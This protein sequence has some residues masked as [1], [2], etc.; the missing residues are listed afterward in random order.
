MGNRTEQ[1]GYPEFINPEF[2]PFL[3]I[4]RVPGE[5]RYQYT[6]N[7]EGLHLIAGE[8]YRERERIFYI[9]QKST[10]IDFVPSLEDVTPSTPPSPLDTQLLVARGI[11]G[12][13]AQILDLI[14]PTTDILACSHGIGWEFLPEKFLTHLLEE[15]GFKVDEGYPRIG[16][17][18]RIQEH[19]ILLRK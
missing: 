18:K 11:I 8:Q 7:F 12:N 10:Y 3:H 9:P 15:Q 1:G 2:S 14:T 16:G 13:A 5:N 17:R 6:A 4:L 19:A